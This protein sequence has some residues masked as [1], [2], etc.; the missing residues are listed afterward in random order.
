[1]A[2]K[3]RAGQS[4]DRCEHVPH[5][6]AIA[7]DLL[8]FAEHAQAAAFELTLPSKLDRNSAWSL[9][10]IELEALRWTMDGMTSW[11][12][13]NRM[14]ISER[15]VTLLLRRAMQKLGCSSRYETGLR[16]IKLGLIACP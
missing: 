3:N 2:R 8:Q 9:A 12:V 14:S 1:M 4:N 6:K 16:A 13:A 10:G 5:F 11:E 7:E 15:H